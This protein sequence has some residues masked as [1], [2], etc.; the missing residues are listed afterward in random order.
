MSNLHSP[1]YLYHQIKST[2][3]Y[4]HVIQQH[5][6]KQH[7]LTQLL[8]HSH[9]PRTSQKR[10]LLAKT[11]LTLIISF[12]TFSVVCFFSPA[13][14]FLYGRCTQ[15]RYTANTPYESNLNLATYSSY[16]NL[17]V[18][19]STQSGDAI[20]GLHQ[21]GRDLAMPETAS[22]MLKTSAWQRVATPSNW[23]VAS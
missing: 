22:P 16:N 13:D 9:Q 20:Y 3:T 7:A 21:C 4:M 2:M 15:Q 19:G 18:V 12:A 1:G 23:S 11:K 17:I 10:L 14:F 5:Y 6:H 8:I